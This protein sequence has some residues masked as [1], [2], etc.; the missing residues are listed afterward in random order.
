MFHKNYISKV[1]EFIIKDCK[2]FKSFCY[3]LSFI[4]FNDFLFPVIGRHGSIEIDH[5]EEYQEFKVRILAKFYSNY[6]GSEEMEMLVQ[7]L[8]M[9]LASISDC[10]LTVSEV[11]ILI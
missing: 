5:I 9:L 8:Q 3:L 6:D 10:K 7:K 1:A 2:D 4:D 11:N